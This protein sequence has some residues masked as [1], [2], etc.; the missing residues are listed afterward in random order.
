MIRKCIICPNTYE[1][2]HDE[3]YMRDTCSEFCRR[4]KYRQITLMK[5]IDEAIKSGNYGK[6][7]L[8]MKLSTITNAGYQV[9]I[10]KKQ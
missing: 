4:I 9:T 6:D 2:K 1:S 5:K 8:S 7:I 3:E 10:S